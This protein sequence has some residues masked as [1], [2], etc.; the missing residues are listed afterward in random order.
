MS[1]SGWERTDPPAGIARRYRP[2]GSGDRDG[3]RCGDR[4]LPPG[5]GESRRFG[6]LRAAGGHGW[7][8]IAAR[9]LCPRPPPE[10]VDTSPVGRGVSLVRCSRS[11]R[12]GL[13]EICDIGRSPLRAGAA[14]KAPLWSCCGAAP[15]R[16]GP[17]QVSHG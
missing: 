14:A 9:P 16:Q 7:H 15:S 11:L 2:T 10:P 8:S 12:T 3:D 6:M 5:C 1:G 17:P 4:F 13:R